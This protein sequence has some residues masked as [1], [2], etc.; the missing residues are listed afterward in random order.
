MTL[1]HCQRYIQIAFCNSRGKR[2]KILKRRD[3]RLSD[4]DVPRDNDKDLKHSDNAEEHYDVLLNTLELLV[5]AIVEDDLSNRLSV[6][7]KV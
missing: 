2:I 4:I 5:H 3:N 1:V 6:H 7:F